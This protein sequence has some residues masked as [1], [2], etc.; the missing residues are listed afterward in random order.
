MRPARASVPSV[1]EVWKASVIHR[2]ALHCICDK[3][4]K[5]VLF[6][7][8]LKNHSLNLYVAIGRMQAW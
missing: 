6:L 7:A 8:P 2:A 5:A 3:I 1:G 4:L